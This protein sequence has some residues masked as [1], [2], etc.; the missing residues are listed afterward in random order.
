MAVWY[1]FMAVW[2]ILCLFGIFLYIL[3]FGILYQE[4]FGS[5]AINVVAFCLSDLLTGP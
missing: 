5:P 4:K 1:I 2:Y 3:R